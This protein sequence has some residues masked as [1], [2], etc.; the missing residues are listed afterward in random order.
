MKYQMS[1]SWNG[2]RNQVKGLGA[3]GTGLGATLIRSVSGSPGLARTTLPSTRSTSGSVGYWNPGRSPVT[4][5]SVHR[6]AA[7]CSA[8]VMAPETVTGSPAARVAEARATP[9]SAG[10]A[11]ASAPAVVG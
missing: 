5:T 9:L 3:S 8:T 1:P 6:R 11:G 10:G 4:V 7:G 2:Q